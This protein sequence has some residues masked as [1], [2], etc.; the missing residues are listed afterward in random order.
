MQ[1]SAVAPPPACRALGTPRLVLQPGALRAP[2]VQRAARGRQLA[3]RRRLVLL[4]R[5]ALRPQLLQARGHARRRVVRRA[6]LLLVRLLRG[7][8]GGARNCGLRAPLLLFLSTDFG[9][10]Q[11]CCRS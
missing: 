5:G 1:P 10:G 6:Q 9:A 4:E 2:A 3:L 11:D 8:R 7:Q